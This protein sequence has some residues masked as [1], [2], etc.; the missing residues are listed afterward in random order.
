MVY[1]AAPFQVASDNLLD[2]DIYCLDW[3]LSEYSRLRAVVR[4]VGRNLGTPRSAV[5]WERR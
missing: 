1:N 5:T 3:L 2:V 4:L